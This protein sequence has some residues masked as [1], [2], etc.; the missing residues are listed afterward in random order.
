MNNNKI[1]EA[2]KYYTIKS[3]EIIDK[4]NVSN[5]LKVDEI[6]SLGR[7]LFVLENKLTALEVANEN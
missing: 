7:Q 1:E 4:V 5:N 2:F 6:I 3:K